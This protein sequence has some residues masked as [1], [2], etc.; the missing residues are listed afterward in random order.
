MTFFCRIQ[1]KDAPS[2]SVTY[3]LFY[4][5]TAKKQVFFYKAISS[6]YAFL[7]K[8]VQ[9]LLIYLNLQID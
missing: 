5:I 3:L 4:M 1:N 9:F 6:I 8:N 2:D 7:Q